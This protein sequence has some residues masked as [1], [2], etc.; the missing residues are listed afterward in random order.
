MR[1]W[2]SLSIKS[3]AFGRSL[4]LRCATGSAGSGDSVVSGTAVTSATRTEY[5]VRFNCG[6]S[7]KASLSHRWGVIAH[8]IGHNFGA[9]HDV[10]FH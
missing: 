3:W 2:I 4:C 7:S 6:T 5:V 1:I 9:I 8:E 10:R